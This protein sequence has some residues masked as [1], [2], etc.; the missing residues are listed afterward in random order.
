MKLNEKEKYKVNKKDTCY[1]LKIIY[2][3]IIVM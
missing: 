1:Y 2:F 3:E